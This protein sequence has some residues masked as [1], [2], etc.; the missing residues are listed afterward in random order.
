MS[1]SW[2]KG[3]MIRERIGEDALADLV[4]LQRL[5]DAGLRVGC[6]SDWG[7]KN[8]FEQIAL[9]VE[10]VYGGSNRQAATPGIAR[11]AALSMWTR[12]AARVIG[13]E[14]I[15]TLEPGNHADLTVVDRDPLTAPLDELPETEVRAT[16]LGGETVHGGLEEVVRS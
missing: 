9:A 7:P 6:G 3:E 15:G 8:V 2:G 10:P 1:F 12:E 4:P 13:W 16:L 5:L 11:D 14:G